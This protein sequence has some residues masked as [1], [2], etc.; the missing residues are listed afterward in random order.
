MAAAGVGATL[1]LKL[2]NLM[3]GEH[4]KPEYLQVN[5]LQVL[6]LFVNAIDLHSIPPRPR[7]NSST[8]FAFIILLQSQ[9]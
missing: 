2:T 8:R 5:K 1:N 9:T 3:A 4:M 7:W 6:N